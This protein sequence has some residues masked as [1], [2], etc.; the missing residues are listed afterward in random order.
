LFAGLFGFIIHPMELG[1]VWL[2]AAVGSAGIAIILFTIF[3]RLILS[4]LTITQLRNAKAMQRLQ[5]LMAELRQKHGK[6]RQALSEATMALYKEHKVNPAMGCLPTLL[7]FPILIGLF[8]ALLHL[9]SAP[10]GYP[11]HIVWSKVTC[12]GHSVSGW[13][14]WLHACYAQ[15]GWAVG[16]A[17]VFALFHAQFLWLSNGLGMP[18]PLYILP[19]LAGVTQW[20]QSRMMLTQASSNDPQQ[21]MMNTMMNFMPLMIVFFALRYA[22]GLS[23]YWVTSTTIGIIIQYRITGWGLLPSTVG[24]LLRNVRGVSRPSSRP[25]P[26]RSSPPKAPKTKPSLATNGNGGTAPV[27]TARTRMAMESTGTNGQDGDGTASPETSEVV[28]P[29]KKANR[30]RGGRGGRRG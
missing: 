8:Y 5:P 25:A 4:P 2:A 1:L 3:V 19:I 17:H 16:P 27:D 30:A 18:D 13:V 15:Q 24:G 9:G 22:S 29:R 11:H 10:T 21:Q 14:P 28:R 26:Q 20:I 12:N 23:L 6:D 7:Q